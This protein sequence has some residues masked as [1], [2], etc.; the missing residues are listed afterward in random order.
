M[1]V[2]LIKETSN[3]QSTVNLLFQNS[4]TPILVETESGVEGLMIGNGKNILL[5]EIPKEANIEVGEKVMTLGQ[6][7]I[8]PQLFVGQ[9]Q[10]IIDRPSSPIKEAIISQETSFYEA[11]IVE[12]LP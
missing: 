6:E 5:T 1:L 4:T 9:I 2:G 11:S 7:Q 10:Q 8:K 12:V 3:Y